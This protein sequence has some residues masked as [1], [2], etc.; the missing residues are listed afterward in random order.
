M[1]SRTTST[2]VFNVL[3]RREQPFF[4]ESTVPY[5]TDVYD[6]LLRL[7]DILEMQRDLLAGALESHLSI[8]SNQLNQ[9]VRTLT[10]VTLIVMVPTLIAGVYGMNF[11]LF[12]PNDWETSFWIALGMMVLTGLGLTA[13]FKHLHWL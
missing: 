4:H 1:H 3:S 5:F 7:S 10:A 2:T 8:Q 12:P 11:P 9:T 6:H 13:Y